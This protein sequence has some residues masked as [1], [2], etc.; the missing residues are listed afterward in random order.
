[1]L[2][3]Y[4]LLTGLILLGGVDIHVKP[5]TGP[6]F[7]AQWVGVET[8]A[9]VVLQDG[10]TRRLP[11][12]GLREIA[13]VAPA[14]APSALMTIWV[15]LVDGSQLL[16]SRYQVTDGS[17]R[18]RLING[19][20]LEVRTRSIRSVRFRDHS[21]TPAIARQWQEIAQAKHSGDVIII[22]RQESLDFLEGT[23]VEI[24]D[25]TVGF[26]FDGDKIQ[27]NRQRLDGLVYYHPL[28]RQLPE[29]V[30]QL[31]D[32]S[33][34]RWMVRALALDDG[35]IEWTSPA[36]VKL[37]IPVEQLGKLDFSSGNTVWLSDLEPEFSQR[38]PYVASRLPPSS[39]ERLFGPRRDVGMTGGPLVLDGET[40]SRGIA[41]TSR[42]EMVYRLTEDFRHFH[43][44]V[45]IDDAVRDAGHVELVIS[46]DDRV[47][48]SRTVTG[49]EQAF[50]IE[51]DVAGV[52]RLKILVDFGEQM[53]IADH[54]NLCD[55]RLTK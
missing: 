49:R 53:D 27:V 35:K 51:L 30:C 42:T 3:N 14:T 50:P 20:E 48:L 5:L 1:M 46:G 38:R 16:A 41:M 7:R 6:G 28:A 34:S 4:T 11:W 12:S 43:A 45:G 19:Q 18:I 21:A 47:L 29:R 8:D 15:E 17:A 22:R 32:V 23:L 24:D 13:P 44:M 36:G 25:D 39:L 2:L 54:L 52:R 55:A 33:G 31:I 37:S 40:Y 9:V 10:Q 26:E